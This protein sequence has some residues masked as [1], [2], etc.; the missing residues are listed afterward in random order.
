MKKNIV[1]L[2]GVLMMVVLNARANDDWRKLSE[3]PEY[4]HRSI[5]QVTDVI[6]H[7]IYSPPVASRIYAYVTI[8]AYEAAL[9]ADENYISFA[10]QLH[11]LTPLPQP[12]AGSKYSYTLAAV[13]ALLRVARSM[14]ISEEKI[15]SFQDK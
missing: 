6:V 4:L 3:D 2:A 9:H 7:D 1:L 8:A 14:I 15:T 12:D 10:G 5:K 13:D 11:H